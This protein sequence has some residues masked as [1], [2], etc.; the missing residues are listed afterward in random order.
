MPYRNS[1]A[2]IGRTYPRMQ[3]DADAASRPERHRRRYRMMAGL[4]A[5]LSAVGLIGWLFAR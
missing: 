5:V 1:V 2:R 4:L 3:P